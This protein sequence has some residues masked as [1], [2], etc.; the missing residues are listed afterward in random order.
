[1]YLI[2]RSIKCVQL[3]VL[4]ED[5]LLSLSYVIGIPSLYEIA[6]RLCKINIIKWKAKKYQETDI[7]NDRSRFPH[8]LGKERIRHHGDITANYLIGSS[9]QLTTLRN[10]TR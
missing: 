3:L 5:H 2:A 9:D 4:R 8:L 7:E 10:Q 6:R 1:M